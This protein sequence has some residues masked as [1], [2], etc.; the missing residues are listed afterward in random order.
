[1]KLFSVFKKQPRYGQAGVTDSDVP[2]TRS[3][4]NTSHPVDSEI[5]VQGEDPIT[6]EW[7]PS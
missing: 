7:V 5:L 4:P 6:A 1:M 2:T 3:S